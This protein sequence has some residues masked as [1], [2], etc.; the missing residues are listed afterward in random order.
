[1]LR[2]S[3]ETKRTEFSAAAPGSAP[4]IGRPYTGC[5]VGMLCSIVSASISRAEIAARTYRVRIA[6]LC[7][8][9]HTTLDH[10]LRS[11]AVVARLPEHQ[12]CE[13]AH[14]DVADNVRHTMRDGPFPK[15]VYSQGVSR[16]TNGLIVYLAMY[17]LTRKLSF[18]SCSPFK[19]PVKLFILLAVRHVRL[20]TSP[21]LPIA[22]ASEEIM[23]IAPMSCSTSSAATVSARMRDSANAMSSA[24]SLVSNIVR[25][26][27]R[28]D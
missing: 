21:T 2:E 23:E 11:H 18:P 22:W 14:R 28:T 8:C 10:L 4:H 5:T 26:G 20:T 3:A 17:R 27:G 24:D 7:P 19:G 25:C 16:E 15:S 12:I 1:M 9:N 13:L 6:H